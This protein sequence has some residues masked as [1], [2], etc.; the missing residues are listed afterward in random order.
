MS[1]HF[2]SLCILLKI[3]QLIAS[4]VTQSRSQITPNCFHRQDA[5]KNDKFADAHR[6]SGGLKKQLAGSVPS[7]TFFAICRMLAFSSK[8]KQDVH[9]H[10]CDLPKRPS[11]RRSVFTLRENLSFLLSSLCSV[12]QGSVSQ[13]DLPFF[14]TAN[15]L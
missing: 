1:D 9:E 15:L 12:P 3:V 4:F 6:L 13:T 14:I 7:N 11:Y 10:Q 2:F 5:P 8:R